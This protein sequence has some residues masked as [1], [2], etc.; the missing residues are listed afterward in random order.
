MEILKIDQLSVAARAGALDGSLAYSSIY[1]QHQDLITQSALSG[2][3]GLEQTLS[4]TGVYGQAV[5]SL[6]EASQKIEEANIEALKDPFGPA[7]GGL[8]SQHTTAV[9]NGMRTQSWPYRTTAQNI[10]STAQNAVNGTGASNPERGYAN[11]VKHAADELELATA[12]LVNQADPNAARYHATNALN[13]ATA[14]RDNA[15]TLLGQLAGM[16]PFPTS[17]YNATNEVRREAQK[18]IDHADSVLNF[19]TTSPIVQI[20]SQTPTTH[21]LGGGYSLSTWGN[22]GYWTMADA[23]GEGILV[24]PNGSVDNLKGGAGWKFDHTSTFVLPNQTKIT[25]NPGSPGDLLISRG[26]HAFTIGN[27][28]GNAWPNV[29]S[30]SEL[31]GRNADRSSNDGYILE[32]DGNAGR[33]RNNGNFLGDAG[34]REIIATSPI[35]NELR[36]DPTDVAIS[37]DFQAFITEMGI[38][39]YDYD[40]DGK[41]NNIELMDVAIQTESYIRQIQDAYEQALARIAAANQALNEL[42]E[43]IELL[44]KQADKSAEE[45]GVESASAKA[46]LQ[47]IERRLVS[48]LQL[49]QG[50]ALIDPQ[51]GNIE[52]SATNVLEQ[53][54]TLT[55]SGGLVPTLPQIPPT[56]LP[57]T[58]EISTSSTP[59]QSANTPIN[60]PLGDSLRR[61][62]RLLSGI[63]GGGNLNILELPPKPQEPTVNSPTAM[64]NEGP[65]SALPGTAANSSE[66]ENSTPM[67]ISK[68]LPSPQAQPEETSQDSIQAGPAPVNGGAQDLADISLTPPITAESAAAPTGNALAELLTQLSSLDNSTPTMVNPQNLSLGLEALLTTL[69]QLGV[70]SLSDQRDLANLAPVT[71]SPQ[72]TA[73]SLLEFLR[74]LEQ[75]GATLAQADGAKEGPLTFPQQPTQ[76]PSNTTPPLPGSA[77]QLLEVLTG[78]SASTLPQLSNVLQQVAD[79]LSGKAQ[80]SSADTNT[81]QGSVSGTLSDLSRTSEQVMLVLQGLAALGSAGVGQSTGQSGS[82]APSAPEMRLGLQNLLSALSTYGL[83]GNN[84]PT[85][86]ST[87]AGTGVVFQSS[88]SQALGTITGNF[89]TDPELMK[90]IEENLSKAL[91]TQQRQLSQASTLFTQSQEIVQKF[92]SLIETDDLVREVVKSD[93]LSDEQQAIFDDRMKDLRKDWGTEW[94]STEDNT[95]ASQSNLVSRAVQSGMMV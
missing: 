83:V 31:N 4:E 94:G 39:D 76:T 54:N 18:V 36:L 49:L 45:R 60:D 35:S 8:Q 73:S 38:S 93:D 70:V 65:N 1:T 80:Y 30:Y 50:N 86:S 67:G 63:L 79:M 34:G 42:N 72:T 11:S 46:E 25:V 59:G 61:A 20:R 55:Q 87:S 7:S 88:D 24:H 33:W 29:S 2:L 51:Q 92:V 6:K 21:D 9:V 78:K 41:L 85:S 16:T 53:L 48:A 57:G 12:Y 56:L 81:G 84:S 62:G 15:S 47:A 22:S 3:R 74:D 64:G 26:V 10:Q 17:R 75:L 19:V 66:S 32:S 90:I 68:N 44:R 95:P 23:S 77:Q 89:Q 91:Q 58:A 14:A 43:I 40:G 69:A 27:V 28:N 37:S 82:E 13:N 52:A 5:Q 71:S